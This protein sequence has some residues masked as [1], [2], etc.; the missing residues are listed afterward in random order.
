M[1][2]ANVGHTKSNAHC[3]AILVLN[4]KQNVE[5]MMASHQGCAGSVPM[6]SLGLQADS[7]ELPLIHKGSSNYARRGRFNVHR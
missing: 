3:I 6:L 7:V 2:H 5:P 4:T 1:H